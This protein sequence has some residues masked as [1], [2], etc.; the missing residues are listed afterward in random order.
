MLQ[1]ETGPWA[2]FQNIRSKVD[3]M[4]F[5]DGG[6]RE[7]FYCFQC[8]SIWVAI[9]LVA[10]MV[11]V[12]PVCAIIVLIISFSTLGMFIDEAYDKWTR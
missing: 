1:E 6:V 7:G 11:I 10:L 3:K 2:I 8:L 4:E 5:K 9:A 12:P